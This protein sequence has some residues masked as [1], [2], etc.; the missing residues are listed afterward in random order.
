M[1]AYAGRPGTA[2]CL[3]RDPAEP[4]SLFLV[5]AGHVVAPMEALDP[6]HVHRQRVRIVAELPAGARAVATLR[7]WVVPRYDGVANP[8]DAGIAVVDRDAA[9]ALLAAVPLPT[10]MS[11]LAEEGWSIC[12][13]G[14]MTRRV[15]QGTVRE[16]RV[17]DLDYRPPGSLRNATFKPEH[18]FATEAVSVQGDSGAPAFDP[19]G[20]LVGMLVAG[21]SEGDARSYFARMPSVLGRFGLQAVLHA[22]HPLGTSALALWQGA[23]AALAR[24]DAAPDAAADVLARTLWGEARGEGRAG[25]EAVASVVLNRAR[26][27]PG[28]WWGSSI[29][30]VCKRPYQ[31]SCWNREDPNRA[32]LLAVTQADAAFRACLE[33]A[34]HAVGG[35]LADATGGAT[36]YHAESILPGWA[37]RK[38]PCA[39][40][41][42]HLFYND[43]E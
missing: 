18:H 24:A 3:A 29:V 43:I 10:G 5:S 25:L 22:D 41:G 16:A 20:R 14:A 28:Y 37:K 15:L 31:F 30:E 6:A 2:C 42:S 32:R 8:F 1:Q 21:R 38:S 13:E 36:H 9:A 27:G 39:R 17:A 33:V 26:R 19:Q 34:R 12:T 23:G 7:D 40:V 35:T 11:G 4:G